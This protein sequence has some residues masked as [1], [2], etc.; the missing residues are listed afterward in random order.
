[1]NE[2]N[3]GLQ[4]IPEIC[5]AVLAEVEKAIIGKRHILE[6]VL[7]AL[8]AQGHVLLEDNP[9]VAK[10]QIA[11][12]FSRVLGLDFK[13]IQF[14]PDL[15]PGDILGGFIFDRQTN[16][17]QLKKGPIFTSLL[18]ADE[19][20][21]ASPKAQSALLE[22]M[23]EKQVTL[24]GETLMLP[25][26]FFVMATQ[27]PIEYE[28]TFPLP[29]AQLDRFLLKLSVGYPS[30]EQEIAILAARQHRHT[31][32]ANL[33]VITERSELVAMQ[34]A[35]EQVTVSDVLQSYI[36]QIVRATRNL[37]NV[38][39]GASPRASLALLSISRAWAAMRGRD[40]VLPDDIKAIAVPCLAHR[41]SLSPELWGQDQAAE[42]IIQG[43]INKLA[44]P[45]E[46]G[47][48]AN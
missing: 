26:P 25:Q 39:V 32:Q 16:Q 48:G 41:L 9:G 36:V 21:R 33:D 42:K 35:I 45:M 28:S 17:F 12:S 11:K 6:Q 37:A 43:I 4:Q 22:A 38:V 47:H 14:T 31:A 2:N 27:N 18:L 29:E 20:N 44:V 30:Q 46:P 19:I 24:D 7:A 8:L 34:N 40:Y 23:E 15:L 5:Q 3:I 10:T 1:M 13:R